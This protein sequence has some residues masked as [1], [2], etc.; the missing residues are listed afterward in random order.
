MINV[1]VDVCIDGQ[2][3][4]SKFDVNGD[5]FVE[6]CHDGQYLTVCGDHWDTFEAIVA[7]RLAGFSNCRLKTKKSTF[8]HLPYS[9]DSIAVPNS[10]LL[11]E[12]QSITN[13]T[14]LGTEEDFSSCSYNISEQSCPFAAV[15]CNCKLNLAILASLVMFN[16]CTQLPRPVREGV[17]GAERAVEMTH[18]V[19]PETECAMVW[20]TVLTHMQMKESVQV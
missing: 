15:R 12:G 9:T 5:F 19:F 16:C 14:C 3:R 11:T 1:C 10:G 18:S 17:S 13:T 2:V 6:I 7:C 20:G 4:F 8:F